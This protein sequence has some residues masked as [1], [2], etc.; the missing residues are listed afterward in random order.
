VR[1]VFSAGDKSLLS[2]FGRAAGS[3]A[4]A[5]GGDGDDVHPESQADAQPVQMSKM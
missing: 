4:A 1:A 2:K 3:A 5:G